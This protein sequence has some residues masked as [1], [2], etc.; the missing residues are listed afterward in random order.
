VFSIPAGRTYG[1][2]KMTPVRA[3][4]IRLVGLYVRVVSVADVE[5]GGRAVSAPF[6]PLGD[7]LTP[8]LAVM[9]ANAK[10]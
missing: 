3:V 10:F 8:S 9:L 7:G 5:G 2:K 4:R 1:R 6:H